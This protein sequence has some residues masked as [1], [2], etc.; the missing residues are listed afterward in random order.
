MRSQ[1]IPFR[2]GWWAH[3][4]G[5]VPIR[6]RCRGAAQGISPAAAAT[7]G[8]PRATDGP[9]GL[10]LQPL[11]GDW[12]LD[13]LGVGEDADLHQLLAVPFLQ[14]QIANALGVLL[15]PLGGNCLPLS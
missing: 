4:S 3:V 13:V 15:L 9:S 6:A 5:V 14:L 1:S 2:A 11:G 12:L 8:R 10:L 7:L